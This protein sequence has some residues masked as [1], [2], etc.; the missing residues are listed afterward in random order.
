MNSKQLQDE[1]NKIKFID[2]SY[3][4]KIYLLGILQQKKD[5][6]TYINNFL[7]K[8]HGEIYNLQIQFEKI[9]LVFDCYINNV[10]INITNIK[11]SNDLK[12]IV[13]SEAESLDPLIYIK[14]NESLKIDKTNSE[15][16]SDAFIIYTDFNSIRSSIITIN[17]LKFNSAELNEFLDKIKSHF[18]IDTIIE[19]NKSNKKI[20]P[21]INDKGER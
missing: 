1:I 21:T 5:D 11:N 18:P 10:N 7:F 14:N 15:I 4:K 2:D 8:T 13:D 9:D 6:I 19:E 20:E 17:R 16:T 3:M 12:N